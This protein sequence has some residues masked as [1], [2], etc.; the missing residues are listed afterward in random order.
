MKYKNGSKKT[1]LH[2]VSIS[3]FWDT[4]YLMLFV[5]NFNFWSERLYRGNIAFEYIR[6]AGPGDMSG[7]RNV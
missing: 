7:P 2:I 4:L 3:T 1:G 6:R 5:R